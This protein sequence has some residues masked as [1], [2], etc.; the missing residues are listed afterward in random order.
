[1]M[2]NMDP[3]FVPEQTIDVV[4]DGGLRQLLATCEGKR[5]EDRQEHRHH[6]RH[7]HLDP[8]PAVG[9]CPARPGRSRPRASAGCRSC[10]RRRPG[11]VPFGPVAAQ[12]FDRYI[13][14]RRNHP[15]ADLSAL[16]IGPHGMP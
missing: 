2:A 3:P 13:R 9:D 7:V 4:S 12:T 1:M 10:A 8:L 5:F 16:W 14:A 6:A 11:I 15:R